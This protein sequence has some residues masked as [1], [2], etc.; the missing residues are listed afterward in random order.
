MQW[1]IDDQHTVGRYECGLPRDL[2]KA[3]AFL[4]ELV[5]DEIVGFVP[6]LIF[7][8]QGGSPR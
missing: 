2:L 6:L 1:P 4:W 7:R 3:G 8:W 5:L